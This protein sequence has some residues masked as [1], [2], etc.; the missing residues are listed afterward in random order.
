MDLRLARRVET[1][2]LDDREARCPFRGPVRDDRHQGDA[3]ETHDDHGVRRQD[4]RL[5]R[6]GPAEVRV[7]HA[8][9]EPAQCDAR[10]EPQDGRNES[11]RDRLEDQEADHLPPAGPAGLEDRELPPPLRVAQVHA[12]GAE[13]YAEQDHRHRQQ[14]VLN[15]QRR[16]SIREVLEA[17]QD[18]VRY[19]A[20]R[21]NQDLESALDSL[22]VPLRLLDVVRV[23]V[24]GAVDPDLSVQGEAV[25]ALVQLPVEPVHI[26]D[27]DERDRVGELGG[28][29]PELVGRS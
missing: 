15:P 5:V 17:G 3:E 24:M 23:H 18:V 21:A 7:H 13:V 29:A 20:L 27:V 11:A 9:E 12:D 28:D 22:E 6:K 14:E 4:E 19:V 1:E 2:R 8:Q 10:G 26:A 25:A 16:D